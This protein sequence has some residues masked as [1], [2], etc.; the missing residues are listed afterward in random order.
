MERFG[1]LDDAIG[2]ERDEMRRAAVVARMTREL[3]RRAIE[4]DHDAFTQLVDAST[5]RLYAVATLVL[6]DPDRAQDAVQDALISAWK[7]V[8]ALRDP[9]AWDAWTYRLTV[10]SCYRLA[11]VGRQAGPGLTRET[12]MS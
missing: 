7:D 8:R 11:K 3:V 6:R 12:N 4:G 1:C 2:Q 9:D 10:W 5:G